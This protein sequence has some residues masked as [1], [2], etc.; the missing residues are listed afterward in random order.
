MPTPHGDFHQP[1][2]LTNRKGFDKRYEEAIE[3]CKNGLPPKEAIEVAF[4]VILSSQK[5][6]DWKRF[7]REDIA[8]GFDSEDS[9]LIKLLLG[10]AKIDHGLHENLASRAFKMAEDNPQ[11]NQFLLKTRYGYK[12]KK[13]T[14]VEI[15]NENAP[16]T[17]N[18]VDMTP[19]EEDEEE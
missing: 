16:I 9:N 1:H 8:A 3:R 13:Q 19:N 6:S 4:D 15:T 11:M 2:P 10:L 12:E 7:A 18:I 14:D 17:F 5:W